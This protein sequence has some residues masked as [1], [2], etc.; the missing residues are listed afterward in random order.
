[1]NSSTHSPQIQT[2]ASSSDVNIQ[3]QDVAEVTHINNR[4]DMYE[5]YPEDYISFR[6]SQSISS[7]HSNITGTDTSEQDT[8]IQVDSISRPDKPK[9][10]LIILNQPIE[11]ELDAFRNIWNEG[12][13]LNP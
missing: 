9:F 10:A 12:I 7:E 2:K 11:I 6:S 1:M 13:S 4:Q 8:I 3:N 5:W